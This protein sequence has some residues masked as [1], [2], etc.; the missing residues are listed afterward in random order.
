[1]I[2]GPSNYKELPPKERAAHYLGKIV[3][4]LHS[5]GTS[6]KKDEFSSYLF[7]IFT[8]GRPDNLALWCIKKLEN[9]GDLIDDERYQKIRV[10]MS[11]YSWWLKAQAALQIE[12]IEKQN[13]ELAKKRASNMAAIN[14]RC[15][16]DRA[17]LEHPHAA[18]KRRLEASLSLNT[19]PPKAMAEAPA[20]TP[21]KRNYST[22]RIGECGQRIGEKIDALLWLIKH[23]EPEDQW[24]DDEPIDSI[25]LEL[26]ELLLEIQT[27]PEPSHLSEAPVKLPDVSDQVIPPVVI[28]A[29]AAPPSPQGAGEQSA[30]APAAAGGCSGFTTDQSTA[31]DAFSGMADYINDISEFLTQIDENPRLRSSANLRT[32][33]M[34]RE[35]LEHILESASLTD[36]V[37]LRLQDVLIIMSQITA[38]LR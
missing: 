28:T 23:Y 2:V 16:E 22:R 32:L 34:V 24:P 36:P 25:E 29:S 38:R 33:S 37:T 11:R 27:E 7:W 13:L 31:W 8:N 18:V 5:K 1:M 12:D 9:Q 19:A 21:R 35:E 6:R 17:R 26:D 14:Q 20:N 10:F 15:A 4:C 3:K 30:D